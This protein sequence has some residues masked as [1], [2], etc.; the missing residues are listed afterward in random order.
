MVLWGG[1]P[2]VHPSLPPAAHQGRPV[3]GAGAV[4]GGW[5]WGA[6]PAMGLSWAAPHVYPVVES[7]L[8]LRI[9]ALRPATSAGSS[10]RPHM[11]LGSPP[12]RECLQGSLLPGLQG[13]ER[14]RDWCLQ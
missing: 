5:Q 9:S 13:A 11:F 10:P 6:G 3:R 8:L 1:L 2:R 4:L 14:A 7:G 12:A